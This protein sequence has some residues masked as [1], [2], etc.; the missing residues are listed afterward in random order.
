[1]EDLIKDAF[2]TVVVGLV[3]LVWVVLLV[4]LWGQR[5][6]FGAPR[7]ADGEGGLLTKWATRV[8]E[9]ALLVVLLAYVL[10]TACYT[11]ADM[12][13]NVTLGDVA[14]AVG[15]ESV[16]NPFSE[17]LRPGK[18]VGDD[19]IRAAEYR[20]HADWVCEAPR[21]RFLE[22]QGTLA[23]R[24]DTLSKRYKLLSRRYE[25]LVKADSGRARPN[26]SATDSTPRV[27]QLVK[28][29]LDTVR[30]VTVSFDSAVKRLYNYQKYQLLRDKEVAGQLAEIEEQVVVLRGVALN[31]AGVMAVWL[32]SG[33]ARRLR[34]SVGR[35]WAA[36]RKLVRG[37]HNTGGGEPDRLRGGQP[38]PRAPASGPP[39]PEVT[40]PARS[41]GTPYIRYVGITAGALFV[42]SAFGACQ[43]EEEYDKAV[44]GLSYGGAAADSTPAPRVDSTGSKQ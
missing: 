23:C 11:P 43:A 8:K 14:E 42:F 16:W 17:E 1:M 4:D 27:L 3:A 38:G 6:F 25:S 7:K 39:V 30:A 33:A 2:D 26:G 21:P 37:R 12:L 9:Y 18:Y 13:F 20:D 24:Y 29:S 41:G 32:L 22:P 35:P 15:A 31:A 40:R 5:E 28:D 44:L 34:K 36:A 19:S 10:G